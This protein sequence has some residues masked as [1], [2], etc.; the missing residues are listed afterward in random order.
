MTYKFGIIGLG[1]WGKNFLRT[2]RGMST[3][4][5]V[6]VYTS[7]WLE[8]SIL[9]ESSVKIHSSIEDI[10]ASPSL[11]GV[12]ITTP[13]HTHKEIIE[14]CIKHQTPFIIEKPVC[15]SLKDT[16]EVTKS[17]AKSCIPSL[18]DHTQ[19][20]SKAFEKLF[21]LTTDSKIKRINSVVRAYGPF[22]DVSM[23]WNWLPHDISM[24]LSIC[25]EELPVSVKASFLEDGA[26]MN[27][28]HLIAELHFRDYVAH[29]DINNTCPKK[30]RAFS[31]ETFNNS[32]TVF[33]N[34]LH[35]NNG[36]IKVE[37]MT[38]L[39]NVV[40][41]FMVAIEYKLEIGLTTA[42]KSAKIIEAIEESIKS[43]AHTELK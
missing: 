29:I 25:K 28:G 38:P 16:I 23:L 3:C 10:C 43:N 31:V 41:S 8:N 35:D 37:N 42:I 34:E 19:L 13:P 15:L 4:K 21:K 30:Y 22:V 33:D 36:L 24:I 32:F 2:I 9:L 11:D 27:A 39:Q 26:K 7:K 40:E 5:V 18:V 1:R 14:L 20:Y 6:E 12:I 17:V